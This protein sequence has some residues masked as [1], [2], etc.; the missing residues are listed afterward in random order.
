MDFT[1][2][3]LEKYIEEKKWTEGKDYYFMCWSAELY[4]PELYVFIFFLK[5][6]AF[7]CTSVIHVVI[8]VKYNETTL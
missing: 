4:C 5:D 8:K 7:E 2:G 6:V 1:N 3:E